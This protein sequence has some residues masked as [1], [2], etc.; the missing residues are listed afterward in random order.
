MRKKIS[1]I[2]LAFVLSI[3]CLWQTQ[4]IAIVSV[5]ALDEGTADTSKPAE[6]PSTGLQVPLPFRPYD[7]EAQSNVA[8]SNSEIQ[9]QEIE[10]QKVPVFMIQTSGIK[11]AITA[12]FFIA[13]PLTLI[14]IVYSAIRLIVKTESEE[15]GSR[16]KRTL[17][18]SAIG[19]LIMSLAY[20][21]VQNVLKIF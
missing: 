19:L 1:I 3:A 16:V 9:S 18:F 14:M 21:L 7:P 5:A 13:A 20:A 2:A 11:F 17:I 12:L 15:E 8:G 10:G 4:S 6:T